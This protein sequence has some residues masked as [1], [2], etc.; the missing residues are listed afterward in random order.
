MRSHID[1]DPNTADK[2]R[3]IAE[4]RGVTVGELLKEFVDHIPVAGPGSSIRPVDE[5]EADMELFAEGT[6]NLES[7]SAGRYSRDDIYFDHD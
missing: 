6:Q 2:L 1:V 4:A 5:F 7:S 3:S